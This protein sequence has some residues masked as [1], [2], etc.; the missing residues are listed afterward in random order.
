MQTQIMQ[1]IQEL[2][3]YQH[4]D[5][6]QMLT[7]DQ[8]KVEDELR[9]RVHDLEHQL[10]NLR[11]EK[12]VLVS[13][14]EQL[15]NTTSQAATRSN[16]DSNIDSSNIVIDLRKQLE[17]VQEQLYKSETARDELAAK[18]EELEKQLDDSK[19][20]EAD[21]Q[22]H[23]DEAVKL[24]DEADVLRETADRASKLEATVD[25]Y[26][27]KLEEFSDLKRQVKILEDKNTQRTPTRP[28]SPITH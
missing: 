13:E 24:K 17:A 7:A 27:K 15:Q 9:Q 16:T 19:I 26:K 12:N 2:M 8:R 28:R 21:L 25:S 5:A 6:P 11:E 4:Q 18:S 22:K 3:S 14:F 10:N 23:A 20:K 1:A